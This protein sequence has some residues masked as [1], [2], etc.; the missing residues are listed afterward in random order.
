[1]TRPRLIDEDRRTTTLSGLVNMHDHLRSFL[2][3]SRAADTAPLSEV[4]TMAAAVQRGATPD[5]Y[6]ALTALAA[7]RQ[8]LA[9]TTTVV[10]HVYPL[11]TDELLYAVAQGYADVGLRGIVALGIMTRGD[12]GLCRGVDDIAALAASA[13]SEFGAGRLY[14][15]PVSLRQNHLDDYRAAAEAARDLDL[16]LY[17]HVAETEAE[18]QQCI[19][20]YGRR[21]VELLHDRGFLG[22]RTVLVHAICLSDNEIELLAHTGTTVVYCPTNHAKLA[23]PV[24]RVVDLLSSGVRVTLGVDGM[25]SL[26]HEMRTMIA[27]QGQAAGR[28]GVIATADALAAATTAPRDALLANGIS[29]DFDAEDEVIVDLWSASTQPLA[30]PDWATVHRAAP[31]DVRAVTIDGRRVVDDGRLVGNQLDDLIRAART[32]TDRLAERAG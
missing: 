24:A 22:P 23:K 29:A 16:G 17:T 31:R 11:P 19:S 28:P 4:V 26:F 13:R 18:V 6:R 32:S 15:A 27:V 3:P 9:G 10:D 5:D 21:P 12:A 1:M 25:E 30:D 2:A 8:V 7:A 20:R 14:L